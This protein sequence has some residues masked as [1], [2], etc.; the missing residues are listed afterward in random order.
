MS[1]TA[2]ESLAA[3]L[4]A[5]SGCATSHGLVGRH[6]AAAAG[7]YLL[8][9]TVARGGDVDATVQAMVAQLHATAQELQ[10]EAS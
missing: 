10:A 2:L 5:A 8:C 6:K 9:L 4:E 3:V 7:A 1:L